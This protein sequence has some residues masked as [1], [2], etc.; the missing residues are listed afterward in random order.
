MRSFACDVCHHL[1]F[2]ENTRCLTCGALLGFVAERRA[3]VSLAEAG[4]G[5]WRAVADPP[6][7]PPWVGCA[8]AVLAA[9]NWLVP[10]RVRR[11][12]LLEL[13]PDPYPPVGP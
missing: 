6:A 12:P 7:S 1:V 10:A 8:N 2:F 11:P 13:R 5:Y 9:C 4:G 3:M